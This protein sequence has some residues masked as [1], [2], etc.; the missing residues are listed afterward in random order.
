MWK[1]VL[2]SNLF[3]CL[4]LNP[5]KVN[6]KTGHFL[7]W[8]TFDLLHYIDWVSTLEKVLHFV[9][10]MLALMTHSFSITLWQTQIYIS[11]VVPDSKGTSAIFFSFFLKN[12]SHQVQWERR[13][14]EQESLFWG[15]R[16]LS[17]PLTEAASPSHSDKY[18]ESQTGGLW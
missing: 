11:S 7:Y 18:I 6:Q 12:T 4:I 10:N 3:C 17:H 9:R 15:V 1:N 2:S 16:A 5:F 14:Q 8:I 13:V